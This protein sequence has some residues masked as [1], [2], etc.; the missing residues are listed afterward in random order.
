MEVKCFSCQ[1]FF[2]IDHTQAIARSE[3]CPHCYASVR[4]C[5]MCEFYDVKA[6]NECRESSA[7]RLVEKEKS[8]FCDYYTIDTQQDKDKVQNDAKAA[9]DA[10]FK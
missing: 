3:E 4:S 5:K 10:L 1:K 9:A 7:D 2:E 8:N 6:Y